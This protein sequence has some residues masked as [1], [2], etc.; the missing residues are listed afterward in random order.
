MKDL[1]KDYDRRTVGILDVGTDPLPMISGP[2]G[3]TKTNT[4]HVETHTAVFLRRNPGTRKSLLCID[5]PTETCGTRRSTLPDILP[6]GQLWV[7]SPWKTENFAGLPDRFGNVI[8]G[9]PGWIGRRFMFFYL[10]RGRLVGC[11]VLDGGV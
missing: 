9:R 2:T 8:G 1:P 5:Y 7:I 4:D 3:R 6:G 11:K 10:P